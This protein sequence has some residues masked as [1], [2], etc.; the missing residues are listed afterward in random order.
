MLLTP[1]ERRRIDEQNDAL[2]YSVPRFIQYVDENFR[3]E[4]TTWYSTI[5]QEG[6]S[7]LDLCSGYDSHLPAIQFSKVTGLGMSTPEL[8][9]N[10]ALTDYFVKDLNIDPQIPSP[11]D[12]YDAVLCCMGLQY[13]KFPEEIC[14]ELLRVLKPGGKVLI[15]YTSHCFPEKT[16]TGWLERTLDERLDMVSK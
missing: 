8:A 14:K 15:S 3:Q 12:Y 11:D 9:A 1:E 5:L 13:L 10:S 16:L 6:W 7:V 4:L 2:F